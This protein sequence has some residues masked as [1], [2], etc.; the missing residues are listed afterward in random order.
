MRKRVFRLP[1]RSSRQI[2]ADFD[3]ELAFHVD[4]RT[5]ALIATGLSPDGARAQAIRELGDVDDA[6]R[7]VGAVD[8]DIEAA[9]RRNDLMSDVLQDV[10]YAARK[11]RSSPAF[12]LAAV[13]TLALGIGA[14]TAIFSVV[15][16]VLLQPLPFPNPER[17]V[18][19]RFTQQGHGDAGTPMDLIDYG[20]QARSFVGFSVIEG[21]TANLVREQGDAERLQAARVG[22]NFFDLLGTRPVV[23]RF[24]RAGED[25][26][27]VPLTIILSE[28][29]WRSDFGGDPS[30]IGKVVRINA[31]PRTIIGVA[32]M[33]RSYPVT[34]D[35]WMAKQFDAQELSDESRGA[36]WLSFIARIKD[37]VDVEAAQAEV[38]NI[39]V[40]MEKR[41]P[42]AFRE[43]RAEAVPLHDYMVGDVRKP[44]LVIFSAVVFVLLIA[45]ANVAN[46]L[47]VR[48]QA[49]DGEM[50][51]RTAL[52][53]GR[54]RLIRQLMTE[55]VL[56][57]LI[58]AAIGVAIAQVGMTTL[59]GSAPPSLLLIQ[60]S[61]IDGTALAVT[62]LVAIVTGLAFG[63]LPALQTTGSELST[64][65]RA[66]GRGLNTRHGAN[67]TKRTIVVVELALAVVLLS[68]AG[69]LL[70]SFGRLMSVDPGFKP[71]NLLTMKLVLPYAT[72]DST[73]VRNFVRTVDDRIRAMPGVENVAAASFVP[74]DNSSYNFSFQVRGRPVARPSDE[75]AAEV[76]QVS[77]E[78]FRTMGIPLLRGRGF[79]ASDLPGAPKIYVVNEAFATRFFPNDDVT[80]QAIRI[81]WG[82]DPKGETNAIVGV[83][84]NVHSFGLD[85]EPEPTI[86][87]PLAQ[88]PAN[89]LTI[90]VRSANTTSLVAPLRNVMRELDREVAVYSV[91]TMNDRVALSIGAQRFYATLIGIF[92]TV[93]LALAGIGLY[94]VI[95]YA[96]SQ[97]TRE[98][99][100]RVALGATTDRISRMV[101]NEGLAITAIGIGIGIVSALLMGRVVS[102]L[103]FGVSERDPLTLV[104]VAV[105]LGVIAM[106]ASW[107]PA[108]RAARVDPLIAMRGD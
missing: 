88:S 102:S 56:L 101:I 92:A 34:V 46:L 62:A 97:R 73:R 74:L 98:L 23:G 63:V 35:I 33:G 19:L 51:I 100:V 26:Q 52:G 2:R 21:T 37:G 6:R 105:A 11:L 24:F 59:L 16:T 108:R 28:R 7:Y 89:G 42:E 47:L 38:R 77:N 95:A 48:A 91:M 53:A 29:V 64:T 58:G 82:Q 61:S 41:F 31:V 86:Y 66:G 25:Q 68:G 18:R 5:D 84:G 104:A 94:G 75:P 32:P 57:S 80:T 87:V 27:G 14:T 65:L 71:D 8:R 15:N 96:V 107:L 45:A 40:A 30:V 12:T 103:L 43:R 9:H 39:S 67:R 13:A 49:R 17:L 81:G 70:R 22:A 76:R 50:A 72:Y 90:I 93:A 83:V 44:L 1:W 99:G 36:R 4:E 69:L 3:D 106:L 20:S 55:S 10:L 85:Q 60:K 54:G 78:F 79:D